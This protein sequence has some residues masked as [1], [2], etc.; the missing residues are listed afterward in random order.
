MYPS[1]SQFTTRRLRRGKRPVRRLLAAAAL[2][3]A[4]LV[5][6]GAVSA[7]ALA[8]GGNA[9]NAKQCQK[10]GWQGLV[11]STGST[12]GSQQECVA[13]AAT[14]GAL[15]PISARPCLNGGWQ[16]PAQR[17]DGTAFRSEAYCLSYTSVG[18]VVYKPSLVADP[19]FVVE[20]QNVA[21][22][23]SGFHPNSAGQWTTVTQPA[24]V[25][26]TLLAV[27]DASGGF[28]GS[29][30]F[31]TGACL[32]GDTGAHYTYTDGFGVHASAASTLLCL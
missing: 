23:A 12:F 18:G 4:L 14:G 21:V 10:N 1:F 9:P 8:G 32:L 19:S 2:C 22:I 24:N 26:F 28:T 20:N 31:T 15:Y 17:G 25:S 27:T 7:T 6:G 5:A 3:S 29:N 30:V 11:T 16:N 13:Y